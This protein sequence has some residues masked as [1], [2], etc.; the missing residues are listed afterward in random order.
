MSHAEKENAES[1]HLAL[2]KYAPSWWG[3]PQHLLV[4]VPEEYRNVKEYR[5]TL[6]HKANHSFKNNAEFAFVDHPVLGGIA[7][8]VATTEIEAGQEVFAHY[9]YGNIKQVKLEWYLEEY[10]HSYKAQTFERR[11]LL[12]TT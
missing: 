2:G 4:D 12:D 5:T 8:L 6:G 3:F 1:C 7:C 11:K 10:K 9:R